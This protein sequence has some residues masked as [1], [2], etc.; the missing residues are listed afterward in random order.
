MNSTSFVLRG[1]LCYSRDVRTLE[2]LAGGYLVSVDGVSAGAFPT[3]P[4]RYE[5]LPLLDCSGKLVIPGLTDLHVHAPQYAF[6]GL[7]MDLELLDWLNEHTFPEE[8]KYKDLAYAQKAYSIFAED[9]QRGATTRAC[10]F[11]TPHTGATAL[12]MDLLEATGLETMVGRVNMD[13]NCPDIIREKDAEISA[14]GTVDWL[15]QILGKYQHTRPILT[16]RFIPT[17]SDRLM[18]KLAGLQ[19]QYRLPVQSHL[20]ENEGEVAWVGALCPGAQSYTHAYDGFGLLGGG[21]AIMAHCVLSTQ[22]EIA[23]LKARDVYVAHCPQSNMNLASGVAPIRRY[24][25]AGLN[26]GLGSDVA[27]GSSLSILRAMSDAVQASKLRWRLQD[28]SLAPLTVPE[29]FWLGTVGGGSFF[30][31]VGS[32]APGNALDAVVLDDSRPRTPLPLT[33]Q[34]RVER[35]VY[36]AEDR[37]VVRKF[38]DGR[39]IAL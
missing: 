6:R 15:A 33:V 4:E 36:L 29:A 32:F 7:G 23:L 14:Q 16:P 34:A 35:M 5:N 3:L 1:D 28:Q 38:V 17:C 27:G 11:A 13:R 2:T 26:V 12:L 25:D 19:M 31:K 30:G 39:R 8:A 10:I 18:Q 9:L 21:P 24:L 37:D 20:S 22:A